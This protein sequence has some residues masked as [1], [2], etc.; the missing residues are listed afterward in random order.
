MYHANVNVD[1]MVIQING[2]MLNVGVSVKNVKYVKK[3][4]WNPSTCNSENGTYLGI[5]SNMDN[6]AIMCDEIIE[7]YY[8]QTKIV[9]TNFNEKKYNL[10]KTKFLYFTCIFINLAIALLITVSIYCYLI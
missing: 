6:S 1:L 3:T 8:K 9:P 2:E 7:S 10:Y 4:V 5:T